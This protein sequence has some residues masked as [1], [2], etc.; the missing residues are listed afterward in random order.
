MDHSTNFRSSDKDLGKGD[1]EAT[2]AVS[3]E[4]GQVV[5]QIPFLSLMVLAN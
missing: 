1:V 3:N 2:R 5:R 4:I